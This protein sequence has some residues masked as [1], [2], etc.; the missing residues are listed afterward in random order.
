MI[1]TKIAIS[2]RTETCDSMIYTKTV[3]S[4]RTE[5]CD[6]M[7]YT[8]TAISWRTETCDSMI[9]TKIAISWKSNAKIGTRLLDQVNWSLP[10]ADFSVVSNCAADMSS[11]YDVLRIWDT[12]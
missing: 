4:W 9:Y 11:M 10:G 6:S 3:I 7:I 1:Y 5:T 2:W 12:C 8:K